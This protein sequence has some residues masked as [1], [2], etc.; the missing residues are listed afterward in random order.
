M[1]QILLGWSVDK[2]QRLFQFPA[3][4]RQLLA[5]AHR[6]IELHDEDVVFG[7]AQNLVQKAHARSA[8]GV[9]HV[10]LAH[11]CVHHQPQ[12][13]RKIGFTGEIADQLRAPV[14]RDREVGLRQITNDVPLVV[15]DRREHIDDSDVGRE[16]CI[17]LGARQRANATQRTG[18]A[19]NLTA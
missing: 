14:F 19:Q 5:H 3:R 12:R 8:L 4:G 17:F 7:F 6:H 9:D 2:R 15:A 11:T 1:A 16:G 10:L 13:Q 18:P